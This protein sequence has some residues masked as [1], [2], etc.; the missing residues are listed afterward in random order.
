MRRTQ[1]CSGNDAQHIRSQ[2]TTSSSVST[3]DLVGSEG[4]D[5]SADGIDRD[6]GTPDQSEDILRERMSIPTRIRILNPSLDRVLGIVQ[7]ACIPTK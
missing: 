1:Q 4:P 7:T 5:R 6:S 3:T 2:Q